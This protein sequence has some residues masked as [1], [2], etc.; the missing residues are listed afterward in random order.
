M[1]FEAVMMVNIEGSVFWD[2]MPCGKE[3][4]VGRCCVTI[5]IQDMWHT[6]KI[7]AAGLSGTLVAIC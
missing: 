3:R 4:H 7:V 6:L 5:Q 1:K 2:M